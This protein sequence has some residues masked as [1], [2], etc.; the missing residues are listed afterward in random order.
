VQLNSLFRDLLL[1]V[2]HTLYFTPDHIINPLSLRL[3]IIHR[4]IGRIL[5]LSNAGNYINY[6]LRDIN[7]MDI[8][9]NRSTELE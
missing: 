1:P 9:E 7:E 4:A 3:L 6:I 8:K 5:N 2:I